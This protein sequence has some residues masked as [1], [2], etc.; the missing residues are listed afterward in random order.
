[1]T[2]LLLRLCLLNRTLVI[3]AKLLHFD[4]QFL[5]QL[6]C[7]LLSLSSRAFRFNPGRFR[8]SQC[9]GRR[10]STS[11]RF[12]AYFGDSSSTFLRFTLGRFCQCALMNCVCL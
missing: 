9:L 1:M 11:F 6:P 3:C 4:F 8:F 10:L 2:T 5:L 12:T 7:L